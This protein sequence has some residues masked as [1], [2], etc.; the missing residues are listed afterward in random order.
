M[1]DLMVIA[2]TALTCCK[3]AG[4]CHARHLNIPMRRRGSPIPPVL[5]EPATVG[6]PYSPRGLLSDR[7]RAMVS[8]RDESTRKVMCNDWLTTRHRHDRAALGP[9]LELLAGWQ[10]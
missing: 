1:V 7:L 5:Q 2:R 6:Y 8:I 4:S 9:D 10:G 3:T